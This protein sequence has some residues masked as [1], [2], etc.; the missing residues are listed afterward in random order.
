M[1]KQAML[2]AGGVLREEACAVLP[3]GAAV[4]ESREDDRVKMRDQGTDRG[5]PAT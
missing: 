2:E 5:I 1:P 3:L 4:Q